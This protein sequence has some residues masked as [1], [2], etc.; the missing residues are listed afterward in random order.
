[1]KH[2]KFFKQ[3]KVKTIILII[4][5]IQTLPNENTTFKKIYN[6]KL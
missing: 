1:M 5:S 2:L 4:I 6:F 3:N